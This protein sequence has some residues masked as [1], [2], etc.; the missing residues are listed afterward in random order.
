MNEKALGDSI[1]RLVEDRELREE[2]GRNGITRA[3]KKYNWEHI[4]DEYLNI[5]KKIVG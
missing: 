4:V 2:M 5:Y 1:T 3:Q